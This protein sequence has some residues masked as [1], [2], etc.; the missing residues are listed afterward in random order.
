MTRHRQPPGGR[1]LPP[2]PVAVGFDYGFAAR[3]LRMVWQDWQIL[4]YLGYD[5]RNSLYYLGKNTPNH[6]V[7]ERLYILYVE[8]FHEKPPL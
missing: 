4:Q 3:R 1:Q 6:V 5:N 8:T 2:R 7:G